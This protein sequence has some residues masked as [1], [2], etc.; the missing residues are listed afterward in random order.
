MTRILTYLILLNILTSCQTKETNPILLSKIQAFA[1]L[2]GSSIGIAYMNIK[3]TS[4]QSITL[5]NFSSPQFSS[6]SL[7]ES[8]L[9]EGVIKMKHIEK[10]VIDSGEEIILKQGGKH[11][12]LNNNLDFL[13]INDVIQINISHSYGTT[14]ASSK[15][16]NRS[17]N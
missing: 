13:E 14:I 2:N 4:D 17:F 16:L 7:H 11:L 12:M 3:N 8:L 9:S 10:L 1:P 5:N 6:V 15:L